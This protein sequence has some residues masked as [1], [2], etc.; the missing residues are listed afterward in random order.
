MNKILID[1]LKDT[2][3]LE[4]EF[5]FDFLK[6]KEE[7]L[8]TEFWH[9]HYVPPQ[10]F[11]TT[12]APPEVHKQYKQCTIT[13]YDPRKSSK[14]L[15]EYFAWRDENQK[16][17][18]YYS[19][20]IKDRKWYYTEVAD[21]Y[22]YLKQI[23]NDITDRPVL[24]K[25]V[26]SLPGHGLGWHSHQNDP[27][28]LKL[29]RPEQC[30][31]HIPI[32]QDKDVAFMIRDDLPDDRMYFDTLDNYKKDVR[33]SIGSFLPGKVYFFNGYKIHA[34]KNYSA[35]ERIDILLYNDIDE[36]PKLENIMKRALKL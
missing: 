5:D 34:Y 18:S 27:V 25:I 1:K 20:D 23:I 2:N 21:N 24:C 33:V 28:F 32:V 35:N 31:L 10:Y 17:I 14:C 16:I 30:I 6:L 19:L 15:T 11:F 8:K 26:R 22:P 12:E 13:T 29:N 9:N 7:V 36:N 3:F 4:V